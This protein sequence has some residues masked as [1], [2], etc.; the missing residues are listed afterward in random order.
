MTAKCISRRGMALLMALVAMAVISVVLAVMTSQIVTQRQMARQRQ[1]QLQADWLARAGVEFAAAKLLESPTPFMD[2]K[3]EL[4]PDSKLRIV[5]E[6]GEAD[7]FQ[8]TAE[9]Q[10]GL[11]DRTV[12]RS[13]SSRFRRSDQGGVV[14]VQAVEKK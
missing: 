4:A 8:V 1:R 5:V 14:R 9:A 12:M 11:Q 6:K 10:V 7:S 2:D 3:Q 13:A